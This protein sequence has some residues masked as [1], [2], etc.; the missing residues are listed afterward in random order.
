MAE[1][2]IINKEN[3]V[4]DEQDIA[5]K[6]TG[7]KKRYKLGLITAGTLKGD[8]QSWWARKRGK[9]DP[10]LKIGAPTSPLSARWLHT[11]STFR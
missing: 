3:P 1:N 8:L 2:L 6:I 5:I 10:N 4:R 11:G 7:L 9:E